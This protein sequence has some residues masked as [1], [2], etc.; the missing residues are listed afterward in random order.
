MTIYDCVTRNYLFNH[1]FIVGHSGCFPFVDIINNT[2]VSI[3]DYKFW[4]VFFDFFLIKFR[5]TVIGVEV[6]FFKAL[7]TFE[8]F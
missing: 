8:L 4:S 1:N 2:V 6:N 7:A 3:F 5:N